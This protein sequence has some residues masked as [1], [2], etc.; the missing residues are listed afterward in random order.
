MIPCVISTTQGTDLAMRAAGTMMSRGL[1]IDRDDDRS[2]DEE[3][4]R[5]RESREAHVL[6]RDD[7]VRDPERRSASLPSRDFALPDGRDRETVPL[8]AWGYRLRDTERQAL[9]AAGSFRVVFE[10]DLR[11]GPYRGDAERL[12]QDVK[13]LRAQ[14]LLDRRTIAID[15]QGHSAGVLALTERGRALLEARHDREREDGHAQAVYAGWHKPAEVVHDA[16]IYR[17]FQVEA[18]AIED[19]GGRIDRVVLDDELKHEVYATAHRSRFAT[20]EDRQHALED[21]AHACHL[22]I[23]DGHVEFPD[24]RI[25]YETAAGDRGRVDL[26]LVTSAYHGGHLAGRQAAGFT[27]YSAHGSAGRGIHAL[28]ASGGG[29][30]CGHEHYL[31]SLL[32]L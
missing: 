7:D 15:E 10:R 17:M 12:T 31:S 30:V 6:L 27:L 26:E 1:D 5:V 3:A 11:D 16:S 29:G 19:R 14:G 21:A 25:E 9:V 22:P 2:R 4:R 18:A 23:I 28:G 8:R 32:S 20:D 13:A 24:L